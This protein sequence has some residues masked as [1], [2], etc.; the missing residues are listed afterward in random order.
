MCKTIFPICILFS[1]LCGSQVGA[2]D[3][4]LSTADVE[5]PGG[6]RDAMNTVNASADVMNSIIIPPAYTQLTNQLF[7]LPP[8]EMAGKN[9]SILG[10]VGDATLNGNNVFRGFFV[11][12]GN[13]TIDQMKITNTRAKGGDGGHGASPGG[14]GGGMGGAFFVRQGSTLTVNAVSI[15]NSRAQG[16][17]GGNALSSANTSA[18]GGGGMGGRGGDGAVSIPFASASGGG[19]G[20]L[21]GDGG[22]GDASQGGAGGGGLFGAGGVGG[23]MLFTDRSGGGGGGATLALPP[24]GDGQ[25]GASGVGGN[26]GNGGMANG[27]RGGLNSGNLSFD[28]E[29]GIAAYTGGGGGATNSFTLGRGGKGAH[30]GGGGGGSEAMVGG[31]VSGGDGGE[32][33]GGGS[34]GGG[35]ATT[36]TPGIGGY[37]GGGAGASLSTLLNNVGGMSNFGGG[38]GGSIGQNGAVGGYGGGGSGANVMNGIGGFGGALAGNGGDSGLSGIGGGG[39]GAGLGGAIF[40]DLGATVIIHDDTSFDNNTVVSGLGGAPISPGQSGSSG[41]GLGVDIFM[42][43]SSQLTFAIDNSLE[44]FNGIVGDGGIAGGD[45]LTNG[46]TKLGSGVLTLNGASTYSGQTQIQAG[47]LMLNGSIITP[48][49][50]GSGAVLQG[51]GTVFSGVT[52]QNG[53]ILFPGDVTTTFNANSL[54]LSPQSELLIVANDAASSSSIELSG[55]AILDGTLFVDFQPGTYQLGEIFTILN[56]QGTIEGQFS[57]LEATDGFEYEAIYNPHSVQIRIPCVPLPAKALSLVGIRGN[58]RRMGNY[59]NS[60]RAQPFLKAALTGLGQLSPKDLAAALISI[61]P[62][63][64]GF[65]TYVAGNM[66]FS[67]NKVATSRLLVGRVLNSLSRQDRELAQSFQEAVGGGGDLMADAG[68]LPY[69]STT[70]SAAGN[71][72][73]V[74]WAC[75]I[76]DFIHQDTELQNP[77]FDATVQGGLLGFETYRLSQAMFGVTA[78]YAH[79]SLTM[80]QDAG[81][82]RTNA[83]YLGIY[84]TTYIGRGYVQMCLWGTYNHFNN[85][86]HIAYPGFS[87]TAKSSHSGWQV[88][89]SIGVGYD[90]PFRWGVIEPFVALDAVIGVEPSFSETKAAPFNMRQEGKTSEFLRAEGGLHAYEAWS[91]SWGSVLLSESLSY[92]FRKPFHVGEV[93]AAIVEAPGAFTVYSLTETQNIL[94]PGAELFLKH[95]NGGFASITYS[96]EFGFGSGYLS[97]EVFGKIGVYF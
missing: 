67:L 48:T 95:K 79:M 73:A 91:L 75:G 52:V 41:N 57:T 72:G 11:A 51:A 84:E 6:L 37:G 8:I 26:G 65:S 76:G 21:F 24:D 56:A 66:M 89:P 55:N 53:G 31:D 82:G 3:F 10:P 18:G 68:D 69:G 33:G 63:T 59:L 71:D 39:G 85:A 78:G 12:A 86:R 90:I 45:S 97:N 35:S 83:Y 29:D 7:N 64:Q 87:A 15:T 46:L 94:S 38:A 25:N 62:A 88:T 44:L 30:G 32:Y 50:V 93:T 23:G 4:T 5:A 61:A 36:S 28:G 74:I 34:A 96:G 58:A 42:R 13:V 1:L 49:F 77:S 70:K 27:G 9:L 16:G 60:V 22:F 47:K 2:L 81:N 43:A 40:I 19:G 92:V 80:D 54:T 17:T 14:G 20:G